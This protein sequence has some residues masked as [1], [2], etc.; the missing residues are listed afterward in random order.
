LDYLS[1][2]AGSPGYVSLRTEWRPTKNEDLIPEAISFPLPKPTAIG[3][4]VT[5][6]QGQPIAGVHV[7]VNHEQVIA[8]SSDPTAVTD[9]R[10]RWKLDNVP[11][12]DDRWF[13]IQLTHPDYVSDMTWGDMQH[14]QLVTSKMLRAQTATIVMQ[15]GTRLT[16]TLTDPDGKPVPSTVVV[17]DDNR[18]GRHPELRVRSDEKGRYQLPPLP[19]GTMTVT[20]MATNRMPEMRAV[21]IAPGMAPVDFHLKPGKTLRIRFVDRAGNPVQDVDV[22]IAG[23]RGKQHPLDKGPHPAAADPVIP[24]HAQLGVFEWTWAPDDPI[25]YHITPRNESASA[26]LP[27]QVTLTA[28]DKEHVHVLRPR[29]RAAGRVTDAKT[30]R[31]IERYT[32][33]PVHG[34]SV[35]YR[36]AREY[37][38]KRFDIDL[39]D[40]DT[41]LCFE[42]EGY[43]TVMSEPFDNRKKP[44]SLC[45]IRLEPAKPTTARVVGPDGMPLAGVKVV[46]ASTTQSFPDPFFEQLFGGQGFGDADVTASDAVGKFSFPAQ[47][48]P[49]ALLATHK[50]G[51]AR[52][53]LYP[54]GTPELKLAPWARIEGRLLDAGKPVANA[55]IELQSLPTDDVFLI[56]ADAQEPRDSRSAMT[57]EAGRF[58]FD[59]VTARQYTMMAMLDSSNHPPLRSS[60]S[61]PLDLKP[62]QQVAQDLGTGGAQVRGRVTLKGETADDLDLS[63]SDTSLV[64]RSPNNELFNSEVP[65]PP[66]FFRRW[67]HYYAV[68]LASDGSFLISGVPAGEYDLILSPQSPGD[69]I[70]TPGKNP[71]RQQIVPV[72]VAESDVAAGTLDLGQLELEGPGGPKPG[73]MFPEFDFEVFAGERK[74]W[75]Q[76]RGGYVLLAFW[77][78]DSKAYVADL[79]TLGQLHEQYSDGR[80]VVLGLSFWPNR[81]GAP[82][83]ARQFLKEHPSPWTHAVLPDMTNVCTQ[84]GVFMAPTYFLID[85]AGKL[86]SRHYTADGAKKKIDALPFAAQPAAAE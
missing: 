2:W 74:N 48:Q 78:S 14:K 37:T 23:W 65:A 53:V 44:V 83:S 60:E 16:G 36:R 72:R 34:D 61:V 41:Q 7:A 58:V 57:D 21:D 47:S 27:D 8:A 49:R 26:F 38:S 5:D 4:M 50:L 82:F 9:A 1:I 81:P 73:E 43:R 86:V 59:R 19:D 11:P 71:G 76:L 22:E 84:F 75:S 64:P 17:W 52:V 20:V 68:K 69:H 42:A 24:T 13:S 63:H 40:Y 3:G 51:Y 67:R 79:P 85:P 15:R 33:I 80:L 56:L 55:Q 29:P 66:P 46:L 25:W 35:T 32:V 77:S 18:F 54:G 39:E 10:G 62:G 70:A 45:D 12:G 31:P 30:G 6:Q 28:D